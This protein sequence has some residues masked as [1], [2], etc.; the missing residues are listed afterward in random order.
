MHLSNI[1]KVKM[2]LTD[3]SDKERDMTI[4]DHIRDMFRTS[5]YLQNDYPI[6]KSDSERYGEH[7]I[8]EITYDSL[9]VKKRIRVKDD[10]QFQVYLKNK[11][12]RIDF[13]D[14]LFVKLIDYDC[15]AI[16][17]E[18]SEDNTYK[19]Y[20]DCYFYHHEHDLKAEIKSRMSNGYDFSGQ[21]LE[22]YVNFFIETG[23]YLEDRDSRHGDLRPEFVCLNQEGAP[24]LMDNIRDKPGAGS[25]IA[26]VSEIDIYISPILYKGFSR[27]IMKLKHDK[28]KDD[29]FSAGLIILEAGLLES[30]KS[31]YD[32][33][34]G[35]ISKLKLSEFI[36]KFENKYDSFPDLCLNLRRFLV[37][38]E[39]DRSSFK[40]IKAAIP[41]SSSQAGGRTQKSNQK[42]AEN[43]GYSNQQQNENY[44]GGYSNNDYG[45]Q[46]AGY[47]NNKREQVSNGYGN[48]YSN[49]VY[50]QNND[51]YDNNG[52]SNRQASNN[53]NNSN[54]L[55]SGFKKG[56]AWRNNNN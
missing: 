13:D 17:Q 29:V 18:E 25:R 49:Q 52:Y 24:L 46:G 19:Y 30:P 4:K 36:E 50:N 20:I 53:N 44:Y 41:N 12:Q 38:D 45:T 27:N 1:K 56:S 39:V 47:G 51:Y 35:K 8:L 7:Q 16:P 26:F 54:P 5:P 10:R 32:S 55:S 3:S 40:E 11:Q 42:P 28:A 43:Q 6:Y 15:G 23:C 48:Q 21:E 31:I 34:E 22:T 14:G 2:G 9:V 33:E 37:Y